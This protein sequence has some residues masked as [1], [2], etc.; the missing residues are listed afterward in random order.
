MDKQRFDPFSAF[1]SLNRY[2]TLVQ[3]EVPTEEET[4]DALQ[5][6][7]HMYGAEN[8]EE[9]LR[10]GDPELID[11]YQK[12]KEKILNANHTSTTS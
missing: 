11:V 3:T 1:A 6:L 9:I 2:F 7:C 4:N 12:V 8:E 10:R 5:A